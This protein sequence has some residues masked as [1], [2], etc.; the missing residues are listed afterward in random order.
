M[1]GLLVLGALLLCVPL[2]CVSQVVTGDILG[3][4]TDPSGAVVAQAKIV[5]TNTGTHETHELTSSSVGEYIQ[6]ALPSGYYSITV[7]AP[8]FKTAE[9]K[10]LKLDAGSR[11]RQDV[12]VTLGAT[13]QTV[14]VAGESPALV[15]DTA[16]LSGTITEQRVEDLPL[17]GRNFFQLAD[18]APGANEGPSAPLASGTRPDDR[19]EWASVSVFAQSDTLNNIMVDGLDNNEKSIGSTGIR[20]GVEAIAEFQVQTNNYPA[21]VGKTPGAVVNVITKSGTNTLHGAVYEFVRNSEFDAV[22]FFTKPGAN[23]EYRQNQFGGALGGPIRKNKTFFFVD[24]DGYRIV[25]A[26]TYV[27]TVP[28]LFEEQHPGNLSDIGGPVLSAN[29]LNPIALKYFA[30]YPAPNLPGTINNY[31]SSPNRRQNSDSFDVRGDQNFSDRDRLTARYSFNKVYTITP[32]SFPEVNG[33][34]PGGSS[35]SYPGTAPDLS[36]QALLS[37]THMWGANKVMELRAGYTRINNASYPVNYGKNVADQFGIVGANINDTTACLS[38]VSITNYTGMGN[39]GA[40]PLIDLDNIFQYEGSL[41]QTIG[42]HT[43]KYGAQLLRRR[44]YNFQNGSGPGSFSFTTLPT[45]TGVPT[46]ATPLVNFFEG[47]AY[48]VSRSVLLSAYYF[49]RWEPSAYIQDDWRVKPWLTLNMGARYDVFTPYTDASGNQQFSCFD[50]DTAT[51]LIAKQN[52]VS[53]TCNIKTD[54]ANLA[55]RFGFAASLRHDTVLRGGY[56]LVYF[57][58]QTGPLYPFLNPP[59][60]NTYSPNVETV[61]LSTPLP[62]PSNMAVA[63]S[64]YGMQQNYKNSRVNEVNLNLQHAFKGT[65]VT[66]GY[67]GE[68]ARALRIVPN[69]NVASPQPAPLN[70]YVTK[71]PYYNVLPNVTGIYMVSSFGATNYDALLTTVEHR[72]THGLT[73]SGNYTWGHST[74]D[75]Q[76]YSTGGTFNSAIPSQYGKL[77][78]GNTDLDIRQRFSLML[79]YALPFGSGLTGWEGIAAKG[80]HFNAIAVYQTG[81]PFS[82]LNSTP[83]SNTG[84]SS[85]RPNVV[86]SPYLANPTIQEWFN[87]AAFAP[88]PIGTIGSEGRNIL[89][90][91]PFRHLDCSIFKDFKIQER[92]TLQTRFEAYNIT[93]T[94]NFALPAATLGTT[95][96]GT[97]TSTRTGSTP[98]DLQFALRFSF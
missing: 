14:E 5:I 87:P 86:G 35:A 44:V 26:A 41:S 4:V 49:E 39:C 10:N 73:F 51:L 16:T 46:V 78:W 64:R 53:A 52:G 27:S 12:R 56:A 93:N 37:Y 19:R 31:A 76:S 88:Q 47:T 81:S 57:N 58:D 59:L 29:Q 38:Q 96:I 28:T 54:F 13:N 83:Q 42:K 82:V 7:T 24:Y 98:R 17:N 62:L 67:V 15:T 2:C 34:Q 18:L 45:L 33:V 20:P 80:W 70:S 40:L 84:V 66:V 77:E 21:E 91:P 43:L 61:G 55:P 92:Y 71:R 25:Q 68:F 11:L 23:A 30:L 94:P 60:Y 3:T 6:T 74:G 75:F 97:I 90:G 79:N 32:D 48:S 1:K 50:P 36:Q 22:N 85:D 72:L 89:F 95:T 65:V 69:I 9:V 63:S 8:G